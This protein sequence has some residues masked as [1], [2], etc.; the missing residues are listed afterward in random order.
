MSTF[1]YEIPIAV[2]LRVPFATRGLAVDRASIDLPLARNRGGQFIIPGTLVTGVLKAALEHLASVVPGPVTLGGSVGPLADDAAVLFGRKSEAEGLREQDEWR[3]ANE[4]N[5]AQLAVRDLVIDA[6]SEAKKVLDRAGYPRIRI[7]PDLGSVA[8]GF[9]QF[10]EQP[11]EIG[12][13]VTFRG[14]A[15]LR[16]GGVTA[17]RA[18][19]LME[20]AL[21][22]VPAI[23]AI[24]SSGFGKLACFT[25]GAATPVATTGNASAAASAGGAIS[26]VY[27]VDR[28]FLTGGAMAGSNL[29]SGSD[30]IPGGAIKGTLATALRDAGPVSPEMEALLA[31]M[32]VGHAFPRSAA[33]KEPARLPLPLSLAVTNDSAWGYDWLTAD[34][35]APPPRI[36]GRLQGLRF[37]PDFKVGD[38]QHLRRL[39]GFGAA[40]P[41]R[42]VR[43]RTAIDADTGAAA[44]DGDAGQLFSYSSVE[45]H[46]FEWLGRLVL[47][48]GAAPALAARVLDL[49]AVGVV[50]FGKT[51]AIIRGRVAGSSEMREGAASDPLALTLVTPAAL[52]DVDA[53]RDGR[54][55][56]E[57]YAAYWTALGYDLLNV[58]AMQ[59]LE[60]GYVAL[61]YPPRAGRCEPYLLT[62]PGSAFLVRARDGA[63]PI[64][65]LLTNGLPPTPWIERPDWRNCP[66]L[67]QNGYGEIRRDLIDHAALAGGIRL[68][69]EAAA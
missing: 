17:D 31:D 44:F 46:G 27:T 35:D 2:T 42:D 43:T 30:V 6:P 57:D 54:S 21:G 22:L 32:V 19:A 66:F 15:D 20:K 58:F 13:M 34:A 11:F 55:L 8:E 69:A 10:I 47:P 28:P 52:N 36:G 23:G 64:E 67:P 38:E 4:P 39:L 29:F 40:D 51:G 12:E 9:L 53:L 49:L 41:G 26:I 14:I 60:G 68:D 50:G 5:R 24:K 59:R 65:T 62:E 48:D 63:E 25:V 16:A 61:R 1:R 7:D 18:A 45:S 33:R 37:A 3:A 56:R